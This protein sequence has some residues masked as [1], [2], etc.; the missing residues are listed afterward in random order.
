MKSYLT[1]RIQFAEIENIFAC[2]LQTRLLKFD[3]ILYKEL[4]DAD[5]IILHR[6][7]PRLPTDETL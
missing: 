7:W 6:Y 1:N 2:T 4:A 3:R 5:Q